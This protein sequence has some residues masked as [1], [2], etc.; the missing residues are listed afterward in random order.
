MQE[1]ISVEE[2][3]AIIEE[4]ELD[5]TIKEILIRDVRNEGVTEFLLDQVIAY[6]DNAIAYLNKN[7]ES[8]KLHA[9]QNPSS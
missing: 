4:S 6:C 9:S 1:K 5:P 2:V 8:Q 3:I 7:M